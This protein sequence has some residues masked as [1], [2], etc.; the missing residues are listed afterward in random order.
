MRKFFIPFVLF[1]LFNSTLDSFAQNK[2]IRTNGG[3][4]NLIENTN[5]EI[6]FGF[7]NYG[8]T[9]DSVWQ[10]ENGIVETVSQIMDR[11]KSIEYLP[12]KII[13]REEFESE[14]KE[15]PE[16]HT[17]DVSSWP[18]LR[19]FTTCIPKFKILKQLVSCFFGNPKLAM[20]LVYSPRLHGRHSALPK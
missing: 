7:Q 9:L 4:L 18:N 19:W 20:V 3:L 8:S 17:F 5:P 14:R 15:L 11:D 10:G 13:F 12:G 2:S 16:N 1:L 6:S